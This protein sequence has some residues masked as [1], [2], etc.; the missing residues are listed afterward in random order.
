[1]PI[2]SDKTVTRLLLSSTSRFVGE[3][4][5]NDVLLTHAWPATHNQALGN[6]G[7]YE[8]PLSRNFYVL[9]FRHP[10][11]KKE[12]IVVPDYTPTGDFYCTYLSILFGKRFDNHGC[13]E[14]NGNFRI[15]YLPFDYL[16]NT[17]LLPFNNHSVRADV[18]IPLN[19]SEFA[20]LSVL[21]EDPSSLD[22]HFQRILTS[23]G[24]FYARALR[25][26]E[27]DPET[28]YLNLITCGEI[29]SNFFQYEE[30]QLF[31]AELK[32]D[33]D[34]ITEEF[35]NG[36]DIAKRIKNRL[37]QVKRK[38]AITILSLLSDTFFSVQESKEKICSLN[39]ND[40][41]ERIKAAYDLRSRYVHTGISFGGWVGRVS[42]Y[43]E[44]IQLG[45]PVI[46]DTSFKKIIALA[47]TFVG[48]ERIMRFCLLQ[49]MQRNGVHAEKE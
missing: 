29:L 3:Y 17:P 22:L 35:D 10:E 15:P 11:F 5:A 7:L 12:S 43:V 48:L 47:P 32:K 40:I 2:E 26:A 49:F 27:G 16:T 44:E 21:L 37:F 38:F 33:L 13:L 30:D 25:L 18:P 1:M 20:R 45:Q 6:L 41:E 28:A 39:P 31:D 8:G 34:M 46:D 36:V 19:L 9:S 24:A 4:K 14:S 42:S 23:A